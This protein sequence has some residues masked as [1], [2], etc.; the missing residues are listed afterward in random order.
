VR[1]ELERIEVPGEHEARE[2]ALM[3]VRAAFAQRDPAPR[4]RS[5]RPVLAA[6]VLLAALA[7]LL[8]PPGRAV[9]DDLREVV[10]VERARPALFSL[11]GE[12]RLLAVS[13]SSAW[14][15][16][17]DGS[18]RLLGPYR[19]AAWSPFG[20]YVVG[21]TRL[22]LAALEPDGDKRWSL[23][24]PDVRLPAWGGTRT[25]TRIAYLSG[26]T[27]RAVA[28]DGTADSVVAHD[29][30]QVTPA[31]LPRAPH[32]I[33]YATRDGRLIVMSLPTGRELWRTARGGPVERLQWSTD[34]RRLLVLRRGQVE[35]RDRTGSLVTGIRPA[36]GTVSAAT[37]RPGSH[38]IAY[39]IALGGRS[40]V[41]LLD[42]PSRTLL[43]VAGR[44]EQLSW[45]PD[46]STILVPW[47]EADQWIFIPHR[48][49]KLS[50]VDDI[51][52]QFDGFPRAVSWCCAL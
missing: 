11:P 9:L 40:R 27:L 48:T 6:T 49:G 22:Q 16:G 17:A 15:V 44:I 18:K 1:R 46:G 39:V 50:A 37:F 14:N 35:I 31:W 25:D 45:S 41:I 52:A 36:N 24:R 13:A 51:S 42:E 47:R 38:A 8:S 5:W 34:G 23:A 29:V 26:S 7:G 2:R 33:T 19:D 3:L 28:G 30:A 32:A 20:R 12:G 43:T 10:G 21:A 4:K